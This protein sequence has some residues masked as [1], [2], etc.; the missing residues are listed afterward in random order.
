[1]FR[2]SRNG[3][4]I[5][6]AGRIEVVWEIVPGQKPDPLDV[7]EIRSKCLQSLDWPGK[8]ILACPR[9]HRE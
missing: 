6:N 9:H 7:D 2:V 1:M 4:C 8:P 3:E 5:D